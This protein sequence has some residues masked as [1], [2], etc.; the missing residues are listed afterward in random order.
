MIEVRITVTLKPALLDAQGRATRDA[1]QALG[2]LGVQEARIGKVIVLHL[3]EDGA[4]EPVVA[5][6]CGK[7]LANPVTEE[8][9]IEVVR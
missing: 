5:E 4:I 3:E 6:M 1:L 9:S 2:F 8:Y 7:L